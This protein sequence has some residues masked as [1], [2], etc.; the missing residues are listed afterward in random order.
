MR[1]WEGMPS[2]ESTKQFKWYMEEYAGSPSSRDSI[3]PKYNWGCSEFMAMAA[4]FLQREIY[5]LAYDTDHKKQWYCSM[6]KSSTTKRGTQTYEIGQ[7]IPLQVGRCTAL[8]RA[9]KMRDTCPPLVIRHWGEH[10]SAFVH[11]RAPVSQPQ[12]PDQVTSLQPSS[13]AQEP[14]HTQP[15]HDGDSSQVA[16]SLTG[17]DGNVTELHRKLTGLTISHDLKCEIHLILE[18]ADPSRYSELLAF[19]VNTASQL[20]LP[21][22]EQLRSMD[23]FAEHSADVTAL[24]QKYQIPLATLRLW[25]TESAQAQQDERDMQCSQE[26]RQSHKSDSSYL[27]SS[28]NSSQEMPPARRKPGRVKEA[29]TKTSKRPHT[30]TPMEAERIRQRMKP[31]QAHPGQTDGTQLMMDEPMPRA[32]EGND[33]GAAT[34][35]ADRWN[36]LAGVWP[37]TTTAPFPL[38]TST[39]DEWSYTAQQEP[40]QLALM[41][42]LFEFPEEVLSSLGDKVLEVWTAAWRHECLH[43]RLVAYR[44][45]TTDRATRKWID[46]WITKLTRPPP[47]NLAPLIDNREAWTRL[48]N[49]SYGND[50]ILKLCDVGNKRRL[51]QHLLCAIIYEKELQVLTGTEEDPDNGSLSKLMRH[52]L[53]LEVNARY[54]DAYPVARGHVDWGA[55]ARFFSDA[56]ERGG[57]EWDRDH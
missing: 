4:N 41:C 14:G 43:G 55:V 44:S 42:Q 28:A 21:E 38:F 23:L 53:A 1:G 34:E 39:P 52:L 33:S 22:R 32:Y 46:E 35:W 29:S 31:K 50:D 16:W 12:Q 47:Q 6:Y 10:Y 7:H 36:N 54:R 5:V 2:H 8:I 49:N 40:A 11:K 3:V 13:C 9:A 45:R 15:L 37:S 17:W 51:A 24:L 57:G 25:Q 20:S 26:S 19:L 56:V 18:H 48:R 27:P 30:L